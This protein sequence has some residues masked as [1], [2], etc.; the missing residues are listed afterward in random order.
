VSVALLENGASDVIT[1]ADRGKL[2]QGNPKRYTGQILLQT[3]P[4]TYRKVVDLLSQPDWSE[5]RIAQACKV[6]RHSVQAIETRESATIEQR[7]SE[8]TR[9][10]TDIAHIG[11]ARVADTI[12]KASTRDAVIG[13]GVAIDKTLA[14]LGQSPAVQVAN[15]IMPSDADRQ[16]RR[17]LHDKLD[18]ITARLNAQV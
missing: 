4:K 12:G 11:A 2:P 13:M 6:S 14:L 18:A 17:Q 10:V 7:K 5:A 8:L 9:M 15:I 16:E 3:R 1:A